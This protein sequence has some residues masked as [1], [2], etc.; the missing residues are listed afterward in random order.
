MFI[1]EGISQVGK[2]KI[3]I[4]TEKEHIG[5]LH[6]ENMESEDHSREREKCGFIWDI[7]SLKWW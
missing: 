7:L 3:N 1:K 6:T 2:Q 5:F 4:K